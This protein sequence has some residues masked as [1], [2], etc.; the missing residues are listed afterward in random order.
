M[1]GIAPMNRCVHE[2]PGVRRHQFASGE[3][4][5]DELVILADLHRK[6]AAP[7]PPVAPV[8][9]RRA[10]R[11]VDGAFVL[12]PVLTIGEAHRVVA[13]DVL[14]ALFQSLELI[15]QPARP[16]V[17]VV[18]PVRDDFAGSAFAPEVAL[19]AD[20]DVPFQMNQPDPLVIGNEIPNVHAVRQDEEFRV[21]AVLLL[22]ETR[23]RLRK[24]LSPVSRQTQARDEMAAARSPGELPVR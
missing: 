12:P 19:I 6:K 2:V 17:I 10:E 15:G 24:P 23:N 5:G 3:G 1:A 9:K 8:H 7:L 22:Q 18:I 4:Y 21:A 20:A 11:I 14:A 13:G 16:R